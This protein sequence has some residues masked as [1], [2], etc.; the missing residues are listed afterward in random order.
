MFDER[1]GLFGLEP[2]LSDDVFQ[3]GGSLSSNI[4][5]PLLVEL[6]SGGDTV[7]E[8]HDEVLLVPQ[9]KARVDGPLD[10]PDRFYFLVG[11]IAAN[12]ATSE[13]A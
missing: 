8:V 12:L 4:G 3:L 11:A 7:D 1:L 2:L 6:P 10:L 5:S 13:R 9:G